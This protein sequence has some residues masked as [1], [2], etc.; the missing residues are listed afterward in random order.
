MSRTQTIPVVSLDD[1][2][3]G[4]EAQR[5]EFIQTVGDALRDIGFFALTDHG[6][7]QT[8][9]RDAYA[10]AE[11]FFLLPEDTKRRYEDLALR[12]QRGYTSFGREHARGSTAA[13]LKEFWH[14]GREEGRGPDMPANLWPDDDVPD[15]RP[16]LHGLYRQ[17]DA[18]AMHL[19]EAC[20][21]YIGEDPG[22][23]PGHARG[24]DTVLRVIHYPPVPDD[25]DPSAIRAGAH[26]DINFI[27]L[28][29][30]ST[31][32]G[33]ELLQRD[34]TWLP[35]HALDGQII[36]DSGDMLQQLTN[37]L[38]R[39]TTHRVVNPSNDRSRRFSMPMF[40]HPRADVD[41]TPLA[42]CIARTGGEA[43]YP[44]ITA[45]AYLHQRLKE[46]GLA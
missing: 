35:I 24:G 20:S 1:F 36:V 44:E 40:V 15:F 6:V 23:L 41:L 5:A 26:E 46:I 11:Q 31:D 38:L 43:R 13:D 14:V 16:T 25:A 12:G 27:T 4:T 8:L 17:L 10:R 30:E 45:R 9:I 18:C 7:D 32:E 21:T 19:L 2:R 34:G 22:L 42:S 3:H 29:C 28:L 33:L 37:G 39:S